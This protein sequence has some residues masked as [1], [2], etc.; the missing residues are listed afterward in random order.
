MLVHHLAL[1]FLELVALG[2]VAADYAVCAP[3]STVDTYGQCI[4]AKADAPICGNACKRSLARQRLQAEIARTTAVSSGGNPS[5]CVGHWPFSK[6][7]PSL[8]TA[9]KRNQALVD[10]AAEGDDAAVSYQ[11]RSSLR[12]IAPAAWTE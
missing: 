1:C 6:L 10:A 9:C 5:P 2:R 8:A 3:D 7:E 11:V 4:K 12:S